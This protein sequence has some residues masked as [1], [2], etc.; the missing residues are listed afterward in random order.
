ML[1]TFV[2]A[3]REIIATHPHT[4]K[5]NYHI[6]LNDFADSSL[7]ILLHFFLEVPDWA[8]ELRERED[9]L[10]QVMECADRLGVKFAFPTRTLHVEENSAHSLETSD[11]K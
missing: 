6:R 8:A 3:I 2:G 5:D 9:V 11:T 7:Q 10:L 4:R 1:R